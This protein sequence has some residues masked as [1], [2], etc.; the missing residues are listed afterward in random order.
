MRIDELPKWSREAFGTYTSL[1]RIQSRLCKTAFGSDE[2]ILL[3]APTVD[4]PLLRFPLLGRFFF[5][6]QG[7]GKT[8]VALLT[9]LR[10]I[11]KHMDDDGSIRL[12]DF[13]VIYIAPMKSLVQ[14]MVG[15]FSK[16]KNTEIGFQ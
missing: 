1:N 12:D 10:E 14:E 4:P 5:R 3:C 6:L 2:N 15:N 16:V 8:N 7:A 13:K 11:G 9:I